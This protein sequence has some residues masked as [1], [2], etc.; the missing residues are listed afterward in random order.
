MSDTDWASD[1]NEKRRGASRS[2]RLVESIEVDGVVVS[3]RSIPFFREHLRP[4]FLRRLNAVEWRDVE[5]DEEA[6]Y[7]QG[8]EQND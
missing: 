4:V 5:T 1:E 6:R 3:E 8:E 2:L 7:A